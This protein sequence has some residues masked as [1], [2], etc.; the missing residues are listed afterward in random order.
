MLEPKGLVWPGGA[1]GGQSLRDK[2]I[3]MFKDK[4]PGR[5]HPPSGTRSPVE[6]AE[7]G[8]CL[9][10]SESQ[11]IKAGCSLCPTRFAFRPK[12]GFSSAPTILSNL[13]IRSWCAKG[14]ENT[15]KDEKRA[16]SLTFPSPIEMTLP[17][18]AFFGSMGVRARRRAPA[19]V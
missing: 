15:K 19:R 3:A 7:H 13:K 8:E 11:S 16:G 10:G 18:P 12:A 4:G 14:T 6:G 5:A 9:R 17:R 2:S 1:E